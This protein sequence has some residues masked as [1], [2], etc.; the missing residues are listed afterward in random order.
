MRLHHQHRHPFLLFF[1]AACRKTKNTSRRNWEKFSTLNAPHTPSASQKA[2][3][4]S[5]KSSF[6]LSVKRIYY[7]GMASGHSNTHTHKTDLNLYFNPLMCS[8][9][10]L[11]LMYINLLC[12]IS[13]ALMSDDDFRRRLLVNVKICL[14]PLPL[15]SS[16]MTSAHTMCYFGF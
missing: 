2:R 10:I 4:D 11:L 9:C 5:W 14:I 1:F 16:S 6:T 3:G 7:R 13:R 8:F 12:I 15:T